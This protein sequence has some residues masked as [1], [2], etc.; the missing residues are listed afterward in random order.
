MTRAH[1]QADLQSGHAFWQVTLLFFFSRTQS[2]SP[3]P[4][5]QMRT[6]SLG[7]RLAIHPNA[8]LGL[9]VRIG[10]TSNH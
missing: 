2:E 3:F 7:R 1:I 5:P 8:C 6:P 9:L 4:L 10:N